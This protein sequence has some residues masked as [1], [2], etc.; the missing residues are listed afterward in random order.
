MAEKNAAKPAFLEK[1][2]DFF[3]GLK[4]EIRKITWPT[5]EQTLKQ[6]AAVVLI[7]AVMCGF[8]RLIDVL[9]GLVVNAVSHIF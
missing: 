9:T 2:K 5:R 3:K 4:A 7:S 6:T 8:I 1:I